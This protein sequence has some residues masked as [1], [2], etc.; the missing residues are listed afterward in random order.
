MIIIINNS[1]IICSI[2]YLFISVRK[3]KLKLYLRYLQIFVLIFPAFSI[4]Y[5]N[6]YFQIDFVNYYLWKYLGFVLQNLGGLWIKV[7]QWA[8][9]RPDL[10][11]K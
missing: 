1:S 2:Y 4:Y 7:G 11:D 3:F 8:T 6:R 10:Y 5:C 9:T